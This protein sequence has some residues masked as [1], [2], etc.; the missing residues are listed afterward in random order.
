MNFVKLFYNPGPEK[1]RRQSEKGLANARQSFR[2][3]L[4]SALVIHSAHTAHTA[5]MTVT[6]GRGRL[7]LF[8]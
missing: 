5:T 2:I 8:R 1:Y 7:L 6:A 3:R 4:D